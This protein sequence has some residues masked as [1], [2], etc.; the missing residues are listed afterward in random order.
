MPK[1]VERTVLTCWRSIAYRPPIETSQVT[2]TISISLYYDA[3][4]DRRLND[5]EN[6]RLD[7]IVAEFGKSAEIER[8]EASGKGLNWESFTLYDADGLRDGKVLAG[9]T[10]LPD[11]KA[12]AVHQ[13]ARHWVDCLNR[14]R[15]EVLADAVWS[16]QIDDKALLWDDNS[17]WHDEAS[18]GLA[19]LWLG[20]LLSAPFRLFAR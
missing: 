15:R 11:N 2:A 19:S 10:K 16:V 17:G 6:R 20:C 9:A 5:A 12:F 14:I 18:D 7:A 13:G 3:K 1:P 4:R 8:H